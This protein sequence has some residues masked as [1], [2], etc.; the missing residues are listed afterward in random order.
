MNFRIDFVH[1]LLQALSSKKAK[2]GP[3]FALIPPTSSTPTA[4]YIGAEIA[5]SSVAG[6]CGPRKPL[7][8]EFADGYNKKVILTCTSS[9]LTA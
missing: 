8:F 4:G 9:P 5:A 6:Y 7:G 1:L 3:K 2:A